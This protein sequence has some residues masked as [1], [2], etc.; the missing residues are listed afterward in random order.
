[1]A[2]A[3]AVIEYL[4]SASGPKTIFTTHYHE[5]T[6]WPTLRGRCNACLQVRDDGGDVTFL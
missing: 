6:A 1:M 2:I 3:R 5:V 4:H